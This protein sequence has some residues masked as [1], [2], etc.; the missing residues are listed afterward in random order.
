[1]KRVAFIG[2]TDKTSILIYIAKT[3]TIMGYKV[4]I[5]D[6]TVCQKSRYIVPTMQASKRY[7]TTFENIDIAIGFETFYQIKAYNHLGKEDKLDYDY[8]LV[9]IDSY[10]GYYYAHIKPTDVHFYV[11]SLDLY[12]IRRG[13]QVFRKL[14]EP[15][16]LTR[17]VI[18]KN[19]DNRELD[20]IEKM[21]QNYPVKYRDE[22]IFFPFSTDDMSVIYESQIAGR[23]QTKGLSHAYMDA[24]TYLVETTMGDELNKGQVR[25]AIKVLEK[26]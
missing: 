18:S 20:Y 3:L 1:M 26:R 16:K 17:V 8:I 14:T 24:I 7:I 4:L 23:I 13:M 10:K 2:G 5:M 11:T 21:T 12:S 6:T 22:S 15:I 25:K 9:D 19:M